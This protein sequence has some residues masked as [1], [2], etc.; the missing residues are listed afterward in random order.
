VAL[1][2]YQLNEFKS[3]TDTLGH[4]AGDKLLQQVALRLTNAIRGSDTACRYGGV[5]FIVLLTE[6][7][8]REDAVKALKKIRV[9]LAS[10]FVIGR[11]SVRLDVSNGMALYPNDTRSFADLVRIADR[12]MFGS[13]SGSQGGPGDVPASHIWLHSAEG[14]V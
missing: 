4:D 2:Y 5:E 6:I 13:K 12:S 7:N 9:A 14:L 10:P 1:S 11:Y 3:V 8:R